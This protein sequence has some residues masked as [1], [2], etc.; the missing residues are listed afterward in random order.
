MEEMLECAPHGFIPENCG[1]L[2]KGKLA[3]AVL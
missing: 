3:N 1:A 2:Y